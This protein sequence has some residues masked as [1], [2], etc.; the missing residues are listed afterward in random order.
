MQFDIAE[1]L[2]MFVLDN[3]NSLTM[4][5]ICVFERYTC[6]YNKM[7]SICVFG[8]YTCIYAFE[9]CTCIYNKMQRTHP[10]IQSR[11]AQQ[12]SEG[13]PKGFHKSQAT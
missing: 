6:I 1:I 7:V 3:N 5:S 10:R 11:G 12:G 4:V 9:L 8:L 13:A 2:L